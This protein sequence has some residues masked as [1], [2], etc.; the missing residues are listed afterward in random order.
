MRKRK[1]TSNSKTLLEQCEN[2]AKRCTNEK[3]DRQVYWY[4]ILAG[5][6]GSKSSASN[7]W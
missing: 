3:L 5:V 6:A 2:T 4:N 7:S 1:V